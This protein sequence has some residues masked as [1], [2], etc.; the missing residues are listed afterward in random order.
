MPWKSKENCPHGEL[1]RVPKTT[2]RSFHI[3]TYFNPALGHGYNR[4]LI[5]TDLKTIYGSIF[6]Q[7]DQSCGEC[8]VGW[9]DFCCFASSLFG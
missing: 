5:D 6:L 3:G 9:I 7:R 1:Y 2:K 8:G 4:G